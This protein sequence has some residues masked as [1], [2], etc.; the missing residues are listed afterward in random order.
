MFTVKH[1]D[2][3][4]RTS[5]GDLSFVVA[6]TPFD[7]RPKLVQLCEKLYANSRVG[8]RRAGRSSPPQQAEIAR[9]KSGLYRGEDQAVE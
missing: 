5:P 6:R 4:V 2:S 3:V 1:K 7:V 9:L 8:L